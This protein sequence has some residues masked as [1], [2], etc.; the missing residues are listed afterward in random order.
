[1][2]ILFIH[3]NFPGQFKYLAPEL[4]KRGHEV[5]ALKLGNGPTGIYQ[6]VKVINYQVSRGSAE[7]IHPWVTDFETKIIRA[8]GCARATLKMRSEGFHPDLVLSH[9]G[10]GESI[11]IK[12]I[13]PNVRLGIYCEFFYKAEGLDVGFD[14]EFPPM[15]FELD[16]C[17]LRLK[18]INNLLHFDICDF[19]LSP[20]QWQASTFPIQFRNKIS[21]IHD[22]IDTNQLGPDKS[23]SIKLKSKSGN[24]LHLSREDEVVTFVN[25]NL[26]PYRGY[27]IFMRSLPSLLK[28]RP[29]LRVLIIGG[30][31]VSYG[32]APE[33]EKYG[34][35]NWRD[36]FAKEAMQSM[37]SKCWERVHFLGHLP[38][39]KYLAALQISSVHVYLTYPFVLSWSLIE[40]MSIG[41]SIIGSDTAPVKEVMNDYENGL[42]VDFFD[43][44]ALKD[45]VVELLESPEL[46]SMLSSNAQKFSKDKYDLLNVCLPKQVELI[47][48]LG[49]KD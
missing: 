25:R 11:F 22:G 27:H 46:R 44:K 28:E 3:Q 26:E 21:V 6:G 38:Y 45:K 23:A 10:W 34:F 41:C 13:W 36:I 2:K 16:S 42:L 19:G 1:M 20:T 18:N 5:V 7:D 14:K 4:A 48:A 15:N 37:P 12:E 35:S 39:E 40:A 30:K 8:D 47:E 29:N 31:S 17:R 33:V 9:P 32:K 43:E 24:E 49:H